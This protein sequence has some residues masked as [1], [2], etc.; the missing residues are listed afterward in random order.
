MFKIFI[1]LASTVSATSRDAADGSSDEHATEATVEAMTSVE[2]PHLTLSAANVEELVPAASATTIDE[3]PAAL[4]LPEL[5]VFPAPSVLTRSVGIAAPINWDDEEH[6]YSS[7][8]L[9][10]PSTPAPMSRELSYISAVERSTIGLPP[11]LA[12][13]RTQQ[14]ERQVTSYLTDP[15][16]SDAAEDPE[17]AE[18]RIAAILGISVDDFRLN[19]STI[20]EEFMLAQACGQTVEEMYREHVAAQAQIY[21]FRA[22]A[23]HP[24]RRMVEHIPT[25]DH[26]AEGE[27]FAQ[28]AIAMGLHAEVRELRRQL[29][30]D[31]CPY[32]FDPLAAA[33]TARRA[34]GHRAHLRCYGNALSRQLACAVCRNTDPSLESEEQMKSRLTRKGE[35]PEDDGKSS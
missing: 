19:R 11:A 17:A 16:A 28:D 33:E 9:L 5:T 13:Q 1:A 24:L 8:S 14:M 29:T 25:V 26:E 3:A 2:L 22:R 21:R 27:R 6:V 15:S 4:P 32:C 23:V 7:G 31:N 35:D 12:R 34:C 20:A 18:R 30:V 10:L